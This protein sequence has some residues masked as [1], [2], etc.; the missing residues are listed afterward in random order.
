MLVVHVR[1]TQTFKTGNIG[2][3]AR[4]LHQAGIARS[5]RFG[6]GELAC[7]ALAHILQ[8]PDRRVAGECRRDE[9]GLGLVVLP[10]LGVHRTFRGIGEDVDDVVL[11]ALAENT[12]LALLDLGRKPWRVEVMQRLQPKLRI[13]SGTHR[14]GGADQE[15]DFAGPHITEQPPLGFG[16]LEILH[17]G[18]SLIGTPLRTS[19]SLIQR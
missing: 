3:Q 17:K 16:F 6:H 1:G 18:D 10:H 5:D 8:P 7:L 11:V 14:V 13:D 19:S 2:F 12:A 15:A 9:P 4:L